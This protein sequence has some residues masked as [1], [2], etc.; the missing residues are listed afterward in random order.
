MY[1]RRHT[2]H[3]SLIERRIL[4]TIRI[5]QMSRRNLLLFSSLN[6]GK[7]LGLQIARSSDL[8][9]SSFDFTLCDLGVGVARRGS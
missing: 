1:P 2:S 8:A 7:T 4:Q 9:D 3:I 5:R 6:L